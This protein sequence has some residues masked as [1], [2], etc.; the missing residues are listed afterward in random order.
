MHIKEMIQEY[1]AQG[2]FTAEDAKKMLQRNEQYKRIFPDVWTVFQEEGIGLDILRSS[3]HWRE[4][5][6]RKK[7]YPLLH[8]VQNQ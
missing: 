6:W 8:N 3:R 4:D 2:S 5:Y 7:L 1:T